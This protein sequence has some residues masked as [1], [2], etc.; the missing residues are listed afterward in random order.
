VP[1][2]SFLVDLRQEVGELVPS[3]TYRPTIIILEN[4]LKQC[5]EKCGYGNFDHRYNV[6]AIHTHEISVCGILGTLI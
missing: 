5:I 4:A 1:K 3:I 2:L 6:S